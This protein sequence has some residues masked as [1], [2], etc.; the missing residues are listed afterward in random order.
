[1]NWYRD[2][3]DKMGWHA[4]DEKELGDDPVIASLSLGQE[5]FFDLKPKDKLRSDRQRLLLGH[6]SLLVM[7]GSLQ[8]TWLHQVPVQKRVLGS[9]M[10]FT[11]RGV[12]CFG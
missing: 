9:R 5:R 6:G 2:G 3:R 12:G 8:R 11:F 4:D 7:S 10:N 1:M